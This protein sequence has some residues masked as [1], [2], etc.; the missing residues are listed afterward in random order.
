MYF[1]PQAR[2]YAPRLLSLQVHL[3][4]Y[5]LYLGNV[6]TKIRSHCTRNKSFV[7]GIVIFSSKFYDLRVNKLF[8]LNR[9]HSVSFI[10]Q[11][12]HKFKNLNCQWMIDGWWY[13]LWLSLWYSYWLWFRLRCLILIRFWRV[14]VIR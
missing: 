13:W 4:S 10:H 1:G 5:E 11:T 7:V 9:F 14:T 12:F 2:N 8:I 3:I 6:I